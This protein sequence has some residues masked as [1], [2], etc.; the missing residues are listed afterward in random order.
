MNQGNRAS[1]L[2]SSQLVEV[3]E[4]VPP[5]VLLYKEQNDF[6]RSRPTLPTDSLATS[7]ITAEKVPHLGCLFIIKRYMNRQD[8]LWIDVER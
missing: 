4:S 6:T 1:L 7:N 8:G 2:L 5:P 3:R